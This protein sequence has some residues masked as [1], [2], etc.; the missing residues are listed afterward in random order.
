MRD[1]RFDILFEPVTIGP[2]TAKNRFYQVPHCSG[3]GYTKPRSLTRMREVNA[4]GGWAVVVHTE[5]DAVLADQ[6]AA[7]MG[8]LAWELRAAFWQSERVEVAEAVRRAYAHQDGLLVLS[9]TGDSVYGGAPGDSTWILRELLRQAAGQPET[10]RTMLVPIVDRAAV[11]V[12]L[13][14]GVGAEITVSLGG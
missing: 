4:E 7:E 12:A 8:A 3:M 10:G 13:A 1:P 11:D 6:L 2:V 14:A 5:D 9:D